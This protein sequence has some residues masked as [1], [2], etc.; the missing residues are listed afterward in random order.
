MYFHFEINPNIPK[1]QDVSSRQMTL[2]IGAI[3]E[4]IFSYHDIRAI[5]RGLYDN[6]ARN[7]DSNLS[8]NHFLLY[9]VYTVSSLD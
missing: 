8:P 7:S 1:L 4:C 6:V 3:F 9:K 2:K 5:Q